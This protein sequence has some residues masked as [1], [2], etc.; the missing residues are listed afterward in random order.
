MP[1]RA[2]GVHPCIAARGTGSLGMRF[3]RG[4]MYGG[5]TPVIS[6]S[7]ALL[8]NDFPIAAGI[9]HFCVH[10]LALAFE[11]QVDGAFADTE[12]PQRK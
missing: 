9:E 5:N 1:F 11:K 8:A 4:Q 12:L 7:D 6:T 2:G 10:G 3:R